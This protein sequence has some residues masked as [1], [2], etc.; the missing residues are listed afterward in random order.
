[1][2]ARQELRR[3]KE[4]SKVALLPGSTAQIE[5]QLK[6]RPHGFIWDEELVYEPDWEISATD[7]ET[8][9]HIWSRE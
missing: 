4:R 3:S 5:Q 9:A 2:P 6:A 7:L 8:Y 1:M